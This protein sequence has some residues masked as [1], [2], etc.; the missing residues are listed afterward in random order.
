[1]NETF[2]EA[3]DKEIIIYDINNYTEYQDNYFVEKLKETE[4]LI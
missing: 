1:M 2:A 4:K 3:K